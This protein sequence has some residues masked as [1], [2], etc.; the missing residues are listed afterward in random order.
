[1]RE[2]NPCGK[3]G[4]K[5]SQRSLSLVLFKGMCS[6]PLN[7]R[8]LLFSVLFAQVKASPFIFMTW[9]PHKR[10]LHPWAKV[11][12]VPVVSKEEGKENPFQS[13]LSLAAPPKVNAETQRDTICHRDSPFLPGV[14]ISA[15]IILAS[16]SLISSQSVWLYSLHLQIFLNYFIFSIAFDLIIISRAFV[17][18]G[19]LISRSTHL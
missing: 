10:V 14:G 5:L 8:S 17:P 4:L 6:A 18:L 7:P 19:S 3:A 2:E 13:H 15:G 1:M 16:F 11:E 12:G 9:W